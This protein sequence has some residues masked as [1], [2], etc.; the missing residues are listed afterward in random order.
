MKFA[1]EGALTQVLL[2]A[3]TAFSALGA[4]NHI[5]FNRHIRP[6][7]S[8]NCFAC[9]GPDKNQRKADLRLDVERDA[10]ADRGGYAPLVGG[11]PRESELY[12]RVTRKDRA[13]RMPPAKTGKS[14]TPQQVDLIRRWIEQGAK[15]QKH[16]SLIPPRRPPVPRLG[17]PTQPANPI[18]A[19]VRN[20][21]AEKGL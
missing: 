7:L 17:G 19:F 10:F 5:G 3:V 21:L 11:K 15:F 4:T 18:D 8:E 12:L 1:R 20:R 2:L 13:G 9:H 16:W 14:L 6:I